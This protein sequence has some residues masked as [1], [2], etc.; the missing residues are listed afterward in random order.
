MK[1]ISELLRHADPLAYEPRGT[2][3]E[4]HV[5]RERIL[6]LSRKVPELPRRRVVIMPIAALVL[7]VLAGGFGYWSWVAAA[8]IRFEIRLAEEQPA[9]GLREVVLAEA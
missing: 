3:H 1:T 7:V 6:V 2:T 9:N 8:P 4:R 5:R